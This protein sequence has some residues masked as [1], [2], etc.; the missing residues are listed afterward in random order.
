MRASAH[1]HTHTHP[2]IKRG[3]ATREKRDKFTRRDEL[4]GDWDNTLSVH[5]TQ[6]KTDI[7]TNTVESKRSSN[8][9]NSGREVKFDVKASATTSRRK[10]RNET[11]RHKTGKGFFSTPKHTQREE[12][13]EHNGKNAAPAPSTTTAAAESPA[14][15]SP[16]ID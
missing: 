10:K 12:N 14:P 2:S 11:T 8:S 3:P 15:L 4:P 7:N 1:K 9:S 13:D 5:S 16:K 6:L